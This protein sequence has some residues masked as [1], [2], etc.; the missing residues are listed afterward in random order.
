M[1]SMRAAQLALSTLT[2]STLTLTTH[3]TAPMA[4]YSTLIG[5]TISVSTLTVSSIN[6]NAPGTGSGAFSTLTVSSLVSVSTISSASTIHTNSLLT[7][8]NVG[9]GTTNPLSQLTLHGG[10]AS[11]TITVANG[12]NSSFFT[13]Y[14]LAFSAGQ[15]SANSVAGDTVVDAIGGNLILESQNKNIH[16]SLPS[17]NTSNVLSIAGSGTTPTVNSAG[18][19]SLTNTQRY[20]N[21][22]LTWTVP[23]TCYISSI[24]MYLGQGNNG[25]NIALYI[26]GNFINEWWPF[27]GYGLYVLNATGSSVANGVATTPTPFSAMNQLIVQ[28][29]QTVSIWISALQ[30]YNFFYYG[31][32]ST[33]GGVGFSVVY[34]VPKVDLSLSNSTTKLLLGL[35]GVGI[36]TTN[37]QS[38]LD[39]NGALTV[40]GPASLGPRLLGIANSPTDHFWI[41]L[42]GTGSELDRLALSI[43]G[44]QATGVVSQ[45]TLNKNTVA[46]GNVTVNTDFRKEGGNSGTNWM[47]IRGQDTANSPYIE[48]FVNSARRCYMGFANTN[49]TT[50]MAEN[51]ARL[52]LGTEGATRMTIETNGRATHSAGDASYMTYGPNT[53]PTNTW[54]ANL[55]VGAT[56]D[57]SG[58]GTAQ[59]ITTNG[60]LHLDAGNS[61]IMYYGF[62]ANQRGTPNGHLFWGND[63]QF[64]TSGITRLQITNG[65][66]VGIGFANPTALLHVTGTTLFSDIDIH[67]QAHVSIRRAADTS[68][69]IVAGGENRNSILYLGTPFYS[70]ATAGAYKC[71]IIAVGSGSGWG[72]STNDLH[73]CINNS[74]GQVPADTNG[75]A[76]SA[77]VADSRMVIKTSGYVGIGTHSPNATL[78]VRGSIG[79]S[80]P[81]TTPVFNVYG[82][83]TFDAS[84]IVNFQCQASSF[85]RNILYMTGRYETDNDAWAFQGPRNAIIFQTQ[86]ALNSAATQRFTIQNFASQ[87]G[88]L[89]NGRGVAPIT[90][91]NDNGNVGIGISNPAY[92]L[93]ISSINNTYTLAGFLGS[94]GVGAWGGGSITNATSLFITG[95]GMTQAAWGVTSDRRVKTNIEP[96]SN[97]LSIIRQVNVVKYDYIDPRLGREECSVIAQELQPIFPNA[98]NVTTDYVPNIFKRCSHV[99]QDNVVTLSVTLEST[100][101]HLA[102]ITVGATLK[103]MISD[104][105]GETE[106]EITT[107]ILAVSFMDHMIQ[108]SVWDKYMD[109]SIVYV[110]GTEVKD[111]LSVDKP[112]LGVMA[113]QGVKEMYAYVEQLQAANAA[114]SSQMASLQAANAAA[115]SQ[116]AALQQENAQLKSQMAALLQSQASLVAWAQSQGYSS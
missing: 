91:W 98:I 31:R 77:T 111:Y 1:S 69:A 16:L 58:A 26:N 37:P 78:D 7:T 83:T 104:D 46:T 53:G 115:S 10:N 68:F 75:S 67:K 6:R 81:W 5:G 15:Y 57:R 107:P 73:F 52:L 21:I 105:D 48:F 38:I 17:T 9:I 33:T 108:V 14:G 2:G 56:P 45:I 86:S 103:M 93:H 42:R 106:R 20:S 89:S 79:A 51:G 24:S 27:Q 30:T 44:N 74:T 114:T 116:M 90:V 39:I 22:N 35:A 84:N 71:A 43:V 66:N 113:L 28:A 4:M 13:Q 41:G 100:P 97:M 112:Q 55:V 36:G 87:L 40:A 62:Y 25:T 72:W 101:E 85:G 11:T 76:F 88:I 65:G 64:S 23:E 32:D 49:S 47:S 99:Q 54:N 59:I 18:W 102:A 63:Y 94:G 8:G 12:F 34:S 110:Y 80:A 92:L 60:N 109:T 19:A 61:N 29:G 82:G 50:I 95:W 70:G 96:V 3:I